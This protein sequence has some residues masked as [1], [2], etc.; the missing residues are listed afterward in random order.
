MTDGVD[1]ASPSTDDYQLEDTGS[2]LHAAGQTVSD[3]WFT[4]LVPTDFN[5]VPWESTPSMGCFELAVGG[6]G[7]LEQRIMWFSKL[8]NPMDF[9]I[10]GAFG[11][12]AANPKMTKRELLNPFN[13]FKKE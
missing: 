7:D 9:L 13:Y 4:T 11:L 2:V 10:M 5:G 3:T 1:F 6:A 8:L 12:I